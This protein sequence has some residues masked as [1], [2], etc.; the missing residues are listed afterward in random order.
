MS[1]L[2]VCYYGWMLK[3][4][5][6]TRLF[7]WHVLRIANDE[8]TCISKQQINFCCY[9][10]FS[11]CWF[12]SVRTTIL[13]GCLL[14]KSRKM[15]WIIIVQRR[16]KNP[17]RKLLTVKPKNTKLYCGALNFFYWISFCVIHSPSEEDVLDLFLYVYTISKGSQRTKKSLT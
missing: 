3:N 7:K 15:K 16:R 1:S 10:W 9:T 8:Y 6:P 5:N 12:A 2:A 11:F 4:I 17:N 14:N 13:L